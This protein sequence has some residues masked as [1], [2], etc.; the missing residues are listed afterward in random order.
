METCPNISG[1][2]TASTD[3]N[4]GISYGISVGIRS[5]GWERLTRWLIWQKPDT[6]V[7]VPE[8]TAEGHNAFQKLSSDLHTRTHT[9]TSHTHTQKQSTKQYVCHCCV[10]IL[11]NS[12]TPVAHTWTPAL[13]SLVPRASQVKRPG[14]QSKNI[15][16]QQTKNLANLML[17]N[18]HSNVDFFG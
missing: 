5:K 4:Q 11:Q 9:Y 2:I 3:K 18:L 13:R 14:L 10:L 6:W 8:P 17:Q 1:G 15:E 12:C 16:Q 7:P